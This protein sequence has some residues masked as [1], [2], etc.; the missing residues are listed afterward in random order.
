MARD[1]YPVIVYQILSYLYKKLKTDRPIDVNKLKNDGELF[2]INKTYYIF[3]IQSLLQ[4][5]YISGVVITETMNGKEIDGL[6]YIQITVKGIEYLLDNN[7]L[8]KAKQFLK[9]VKDITPFV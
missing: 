7:F 4:Q 5:E 2:Q 8:S 3:I 9:D 1:D 6:E